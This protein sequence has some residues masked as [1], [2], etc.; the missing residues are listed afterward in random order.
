MEELLN[1]SKREKVHLNG[2]VKSLNE[3]IRRFEAENTDHIKRST[4]AMEEVR[5]L[6][7]QLGSEKDIKTVE[8]LKKGSYELKLKDL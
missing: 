7:A 8:G 6:K 5:K 2:E 3:L 4:D 1:A